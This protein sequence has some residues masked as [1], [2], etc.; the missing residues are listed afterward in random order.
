MDGTVKIERPDDTEI[1]KMAQRII[2]KNRKI[3]KANQ[4]LEMS[5]KGQPAKAPLIKI[6]M[7]RSGQP[8]IQ[9]SLTEKTNSSGKVETKATRIMS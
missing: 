8:K 1:N 9:N 3:L 7:S 2:K 5:L 4:Q 6:T